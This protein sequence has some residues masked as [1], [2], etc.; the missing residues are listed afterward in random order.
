MWREEDPAAL[1]HGALDSELAAYMG[2]VQ[3]AGG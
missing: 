3:S 2:R 1:S